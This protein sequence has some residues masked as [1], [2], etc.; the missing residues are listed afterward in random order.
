MEISP[1]D[2]TIA[3]FCLL[4]YEAVAHKVVGYSLTSS[5]R[6]VVAAHCATTVS[7]QFLN[8]R[9][10]LMVGIGTG[11]PSLPKHDICL[12]DLTV[13]IAQNGH[14]DGVAL[15]GCLNKPPSTLIR[16]ERPLQ[17]DEIMEKHP[18]EKFLQKITRLPNFARPDTDGILFDGK[19]LDCSGCE[20]SNYQPVIHRG[21]MLSGNAGIMDGIPCLIVRD[22]CDYA[23]THKQN[24]WHYYAAAVAAV[25]C[26]AL[27][28]K[29]DSQCVI[30]N[31]HQG[32]LLEALHSVKVASFN[33]Y[34]DRD[35]GEC[36]QGTRMSTDVPRS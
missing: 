25:Y 9:L 36:I 2:I 1:E 23:D 27:L 10:A 11:S 8:V 20:G 31:I 29:V 33:F 14:P 3:I 4:V 12:G 7:Q 28:H 15:K 13:N 18:L 19:E 32:I 34:I 16:A 30:D 17:E 24:S 21:L 5:N 35:E 6:T 26:K 22:I